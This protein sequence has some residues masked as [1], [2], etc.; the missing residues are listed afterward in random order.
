MFL[1][2]VKFILSPHCVKAVGML[3]PFGALISTI[4]VNFAPIV[5]ARLV[6]RVGALTCAPALSILDL[7]DRIL[8]RDN[9]QFSGV[10]ILESVASFTLPQRSKFLKNVIFF[11]AH[12]HQFS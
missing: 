9:A 2:L 10:M 11:K 3:R 1:L 8:A 7:I 6:Y 5:W 12:F 4:K